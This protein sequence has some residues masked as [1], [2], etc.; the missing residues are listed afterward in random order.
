MRF[1]L[2]L[3]IGFSLPLLSYSQGLAVGGKG[4]MVVSSFYGSTNEPTIDFENKIGF[5]AGAFFEVAATELFALQPELN[6]IVTG[7]KRQEL[8]N[9]NGAPVQLESNVNLTA[10]E[11]P[12][13]AKFSTGYDFRFYGIS[14]PMVGIRLTGNMKGDF[15]PAGS[16]PITGTPIIAGDLDLDN[17]NILVDNYFGWIFG[18]GG[19]YQNFLIDLRYNFGLSDM[20]SVG[21]IVVTPGTSTRTRM[22][23][24]AISFGYTYVF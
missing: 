5:M 10:V 1:F 22:D 9:A 4:G 17:G 3:I 20:T 11:V 21:E 16:D 15:L 24:L 19:V 12:L 14:G 7:T 18:M 2:S 8:T 23:A 13:L 6:F